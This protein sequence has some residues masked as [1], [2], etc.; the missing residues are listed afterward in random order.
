MT[1]TTQRP[2]LTL[3]GE[4]PYKSL[5]TSIIATGCKVLAELQ[6]LNQKGWE[7]PSLDAHFQNWKAVSAQPSTAETA[8]N[9]L[10]TYCKSMHEMNR[11]M[12]FIPDGPLNFLDLG[13]APGGYSKCALETNP[14]A[15]GT[16][17]CL[18]FHDGGHL[19]MLPT[20]MRTRYTVHYADMTKYS[21]RKGE[22]TDL[23]PPL[24]F[25]PASFDLIIADGH[26]LHTREFNERVPHVLL[27]TQLIITL[28]AIKEGGTIF[29]KL[30]KPASFTT[31]SV[32][33]LLD[34]ICSSLET[35]K[36]RTVH[37]NRGT[38]YA[39]AR[40]VQRG[41][42]M[43]GYVDILYKMRQDFL[44][45]ALDLDNVLSHYEQIITLARL[46]E[47]YIPRLIELGTPVWEVQREHLER[48]IRDKALD[49]AIKVELK[50][51]N[52]I[53]AND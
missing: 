43:E 20:Y 48:F 44:N 15:T 24:P 30:S 34:S 4:D 41:E 36:P 33:Y 27:V 29:I 8:S 6:Q 9:W 18:P 17:L 39:I 2:R 26:P 46:R 16:G 32:L 31:A 37:G 3:N 21:L 45:G 23:A 35:I 10:K 40:G 7:D 14:R 28:E 47:I 5:S 52:D 51:E 50:G 49:S 1:T 19:F 13:C 11:Q 53:Q 22:T 38:F 12:K 42:A 25:P